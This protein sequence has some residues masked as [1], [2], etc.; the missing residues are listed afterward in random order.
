[1]QLYGPVNWN[2]LDGLQDKVANSVRITMIAKII[3]RILFLLKI[4]VVLVK[5]KRNH[6]IEVKSIQAN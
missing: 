6:T 5:K 3:L 1:M 4:P 2:H